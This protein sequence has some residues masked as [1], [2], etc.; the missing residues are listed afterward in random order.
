MNEFCIIHNSCL[1]NTHTFAPA[2]LSLGPYLTDKLPMWMAICLRGGNIT[3]KSTINR[4]VIREVRYKQFHIT[5]ATKKPRKLCMNRKI[6]VRN[7][8]K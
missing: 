2:V 7:I 1:K 6:S 4:E 8:V 5:T 3:G